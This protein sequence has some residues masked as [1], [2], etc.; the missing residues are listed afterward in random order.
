M[1]VTTR[2]CESA[3]TACIAGCGKTDERGHRI[4]RPVPDYH[5][6]D[7]SSGAVR[8]TPPNAGQGASG[9]RTGFPGLPAI[10]RPDHGNCDL[11]EGME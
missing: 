2:E 9:R 1:Q 3:L 10:L 5:G 4:V 11:H 7:M 8:R 6:C